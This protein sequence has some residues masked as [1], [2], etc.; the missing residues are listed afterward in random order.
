MVMPEEKLLS[1]SHSKLEQDEVMC[2][3]D[4]KAKTRIYPKRQEELIEKEQ[5]RASKIV[6]EKK[7]S[8]SKGL[9][10]VN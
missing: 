3:V 8:Y 2:F 9:E 4:C 7:L 6:P 5:K 1:A 10:A